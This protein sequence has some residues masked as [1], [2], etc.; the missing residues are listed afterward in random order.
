MMTRM[1]IALMAILASI[2]GASA[3]SYPTRPV[4]VIVPFAAGGPSDALARI[5][6]DH[7]KATLRPTLPDR[8]RDGSS[9]LDRGRPCGPCGA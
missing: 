2:S 7:M 1:M 9:R 6:G 8:E 3:Q 5:M 4:T